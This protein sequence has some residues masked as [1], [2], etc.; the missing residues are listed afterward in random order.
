[1]IGSLI[2]SAA[3]RACDIEDVLDDSLDELTVD[4]MEIVKVA[5]LYA[6]R[7]QE[8]GVMDFDD[9][10]VNGLRLLTEH[11][12]IRTYYQNKFR[13]V[14]VDE[15]QDTNL[16]QAKMVDILAGK[17]RNVMAVG[18]DF[19]CIYS[20]R[21]ADFRNIMEFPKRWEGC[22]IV[23]LEQNYRSAPEVLDVANACIKGNPS[24]SRRPCARRA[25]PAASR[26]SFSCATA[27]SR[28]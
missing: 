10:L 1:V 13:H 17:N 24:S 26:A 25:R 4:P 14:L 23:K 8:T 18:D 9:L 20:W 28:R 7:K 21:G 15:Y 12:P 27:R 5:N 3:N 19:Q 6:K 16:L 22:R 2:S 11:E